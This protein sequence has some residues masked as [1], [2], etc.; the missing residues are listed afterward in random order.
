MPPRFH[1]RFA[2]HQ[3]RHLP[4]ALLKLPSR[5]ARARSTVSCLWYLLSHCFTLGL[6]TE[7]LHG[8]PEFG[9]VIGKEIAPSSSPNVTFHERDVVRL[10][11][12]GGGGHGDPARRRRERIEADL[13][14]GYVTPEGARRDYGYE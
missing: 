2:E 7:A 10:R 11:L 14:A 6:C 8:K 9:R 13:E 5:S 12:P 1:S 4:V 3:L